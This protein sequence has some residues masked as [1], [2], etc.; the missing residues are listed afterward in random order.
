MIFTGYQII[1][2]IFLSL[3]SILNQSMTLWGFTFTWW[4]VIVF[5]ALLDAVAWVVWEMVGADG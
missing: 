5:T 3:F 1:Q 2:Q 4:N